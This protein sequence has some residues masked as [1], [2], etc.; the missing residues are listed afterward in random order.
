MASVLMDTTTDPRPPRALEDTSGRRLRRMRWIGRAAALLFLLW[1]TALLLG[2]LGV[3]PAGR[4][5]FGRALR[6]SAGP[7]RLRRLPLPQQPAAADLVPALPAAA[8]APPAARGSSK[9]APAAKL[10]AGAKH[11]ARRGRDRASRGRATVAP[12]S[13][14]APGHVPAMVRGRS[15]SAPGH[16]RPHGAASSGRFPHTAT[17]P[18]TTTVTTTGVMTTTSRPRRGRA[19]GKRR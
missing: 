6:P 17:T 2:A 9:A 1:F 4:V 14:V 12:L 19:V 11:R 10:S 15:S 13:A 3:G 16:L 5:P 18:T 8:V 7:P